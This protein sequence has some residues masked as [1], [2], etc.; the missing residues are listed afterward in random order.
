MCIALCRDV[1]RFSMDIIRKQET[2]TPIEKLSTLAG[3]VVGGILI[4]LAGAWLAGR[5]G[6]PMYLD[7]IGTML[8]S[9]LGGYIPGITVALLGSFLNSLT[10]DPNAFTY[11]VLGV[12][13]AIVTSN[14]FRHGLHKKIWGV[15]ALTVITAIIGGI[16]GAFITWILY[17]FGAEDST[18]AL[19]QAIHGLGVMSA[20]ASELVADFLIDLLDKIIS[21]AVTLIVVAV[22]PVKFKKKFTI[23][24]WRQA[25]LTTE[26]MRELHKK[27]SRQM[28]LRLKL[29][30]L[31]AAACLMIGA[32]ATFISYYIYSNSV[33]D[34]EIDLASGIAAE[35][36][37]EVD[38]DRIDEYLEKGWDA[39]GYRDVYEVLENLRD[40]TDTVQY[41]YVYK[42]T[43]EGYH[44]VFDVDTEETPAAQPGETV[45]Y[46]PGVK[47]YVPALLQGERIDPVVSNAY[48]GWVLM[49]YE[50]IED[51][52]GKVVAYVGVDVS[53]ERVMA[54]N[55]SFRV[56]VI[57]LFLGIFA[58][59]VAVSLYFAEYQIILPLNTMAYTA[60][61]FTEDRDESLSETAELFNKIDISTGDETENLYNAFSEMT[62]EN[63][64]YVDDIRKKNETINEMQSALIQVLADMVE[65]RD[66]NTGEHVKKTALYK[67]IIMEELRKEGIYTGQLTGKYMNDVYNSAPLHDIGKI[68][69]SDNILNK[70]SRLDDD[71]YQKMK[72]HTAAGADIIDKVIEKVPESGYLTQARNLA[73]YH[74]EKWDGT[75]YPVGLAGEDIPLAA[76][77]MAV[78]DV[79]D[80]LASARSYKEAMPF[81]QAMSIIKEGAGT[82]F[83][84]QIVQAFI[85]AQ[86]QVKVVVDEYNNPTPKREV[87][88]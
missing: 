82:H 8:A 80:A 77:I 43:P 85:N 62:E 46:E 42:M 9:A 2:R 52:S 88:K 66:E 15:V 20:F 30:S 78:A 60:S 6:L 17:G 59:I 49:V 11:N 47:R 81:E 32:S 27:K 36:K 50:P 25:P 68:S 87:E 53:M 65:N 21:V 34:R 75:G 55:R 84:P 12:A 26:I 10:S 51:S 70:P 61:L 73:L 33:K 3:L 63:L 24:A 16:F 44:V 69:V 13:I 57:S 4:N 48:Y 31:I 83:D 71:E 19:V 72:D 5:L 79:F 76:R 39:E 41:I 18:S 54:E 35:V 37:K 7:V 23:H 67:R 14:F 56:R 45:P 64:A 38:A 58:F 28:S 40:A 22:L 74:H 29:L 1:R 86:D